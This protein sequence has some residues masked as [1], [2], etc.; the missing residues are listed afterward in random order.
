MEWL[1]RLN[2]TFIKFLAFI[3]HNGGVTTQDP[4]PIPI[5]MQL[6]ISEYAEL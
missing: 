6:P 3:L 4:V 2:T 5:L 1:G